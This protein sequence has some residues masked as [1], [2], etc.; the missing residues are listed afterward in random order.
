MM[1]AAILTT[2]YAQIDKLTAQRAPLLAATRSRSEQEAALRQYAHAAAAAG[3]AHIRHALAC[4][5]P[6]A[7][8]SLRANPA[9][10]L[11]PSSRLAA[12]MGEDR[13][14]A[15]LIG[16]LPDDDGTPSAEERAAQIAEIDAKLLDLWHQVEDMIEAA[17]ARGEVVQRRPDAPPA[18]VL[19]VRAAP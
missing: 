11:D 6:V 19:R 16:Y 5:D 13:F 7:A 15:A 4:D 9:G 2:K 8:L 18:V 10:V 12:L 17:E 1:A 14:A 3:A